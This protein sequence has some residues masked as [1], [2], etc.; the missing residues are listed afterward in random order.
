M[1][2][3][4]FVIVTLLVVAAISRFSGLKKESQEFISHPRAAAIT[5]IWTQIESVTAPVGHW[6]SEV[7]IPEGLHRIVPEVG[8]K[9][10]IS[11]DGGKPLPL[12]GNT[13]IDI[14]SANTFRVQSVGATNATV[15]LFKGECIRKEKIVAF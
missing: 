5:V 2:V 8:G 14:G 4:T 11:F 3:A 7:V 12:T 1:G 9:V 15:F 6:S 13:Q 10:E